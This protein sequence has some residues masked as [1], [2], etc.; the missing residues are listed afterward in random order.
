MSGERDDVT[1]REV[2]LSSGLT[3]K[4]IKVVLDPTKVG[5]ETL[6]DLKLLSVVILQEDVGVGSIRAIKVLE[7]LESSG[8]GEQKQEEETEATWKVPKELPWFKGAQEEHPC[9]FLKKFE[10]EL[11][12]NG[13]SKQAW[14]RILVGR[15]AP[16]VLE[17]AQIKAAVK[18]ATSYETATEAFVLTARSRHEEKRA[19]RAVAEMKSETYPAL[20]TFV[21]AFR[22]QITKLS[23]KEEDVVDLL[24]ERLESELQTAFK[25]MLELEQIKDVDKAIT[26]LLK[27]ASDDRRNGQ[28]RKGKEPK[29]NDAKKRVC[30]TCQKPGHIAKN[31]RSAR[32]GNANGKGKGGE[33]GK[34]KAKDVK[35]KNCFECHNPGHFARDCPN[36]ET[37]GLLEALPDA[38]WLEY[39][40]NSD[41]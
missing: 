15:I 27:I 8:Y 37:F 2:L 41:F 40:G 23:P 12:T 11:E 31:C 21:K 28:S 7:V 26:A 6:E 17:S 39:N 34:Q 4:E 9:H 29:K 35:D 32:I 36:K 24:T 3:E 19:R 13:V 25:V 20:D 30:Y 14:Q 22:N 1:V 33:K 38:E 18:E 16:E 5:V 10:D